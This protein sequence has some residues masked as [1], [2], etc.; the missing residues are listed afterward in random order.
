MKFP[1]KQPE[2]FKVEYLWQLAS[3]AMITGINNTLILWIM[4]TGKSFYTASIDWADPR[5]APMIP[6]V[7]KFVERCGHKHFRDYV[8]PTEGDHCQYCDHKHKCPLK[9]VPQPA[10]GS[11][12]AQ[13]T[14]N[15]WLDRLVANAAKQSSGQKE[16]LF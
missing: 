6:R 14:D 9:F 15:G 16:A 12:Q 4:S 3:Y 1:T 10:L 5:F 11:T 2:S 13:N 7:R 8:Y